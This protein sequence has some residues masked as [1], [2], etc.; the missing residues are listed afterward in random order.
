MRPPVIIQRLVILTAV[1]L[2][3]TLSVTAATPPEG[4]RPVDPY[5]A[6][7]LALDALDGERTALRDLA[8]DW[9]IVHFW[10]SW[11]PPCREE[12]PSLQRLAQN[13]DPRAVRLMLVNTA[14]TED[15]AFFFLG[16]VAPELSTRL[17]RD[18]AVTDRWGPRGLPATF[19]VGPERQVR[20]IALGSLEWDR[21]AIRN[22]LRGL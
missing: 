4:I 16:R 21:E 12:M 14:E 7:E 18:G 8:S 13:L 6:P 9:V 22:F 5:P 11:C 17:D 19:I 1:W 3:G 15:D 2:L 10:A 20:Y